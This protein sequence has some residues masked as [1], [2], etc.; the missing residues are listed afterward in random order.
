MARVVPVWMEPWA[1]VCCRALQ[2]HR[3]SCRQ[4][5]SSPLFFF[6]ANDR[7]GFP[8]RHHVVC[9]DVTL[10]RGGQACISGKG[11]RTLRAKHKAWSRQIVKVKCF[12]SYLIRLYLW[13]KA[14]ISDSDYRWLL[15][16]ALAP[17]YS[18]TNKQ[19]K[20][21]DQKKNLFG[22][23]FYWQPLIGV[24]WMLNPENSRYISY[25]LM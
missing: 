9:Q 17:C 6:A 11:P 19:K 24:G 2:L 13:H 22:R 16:I 5:R 4:D 15:L 20:K 18:S 1:P 10:H 25:N 14:I 7:G 8:R 3:L 23:D 12:R 21:S